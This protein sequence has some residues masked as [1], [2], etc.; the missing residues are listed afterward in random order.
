MSSSI[1]ARVSAIDW[2]AAWTELDAT[3][4]AV[5]PGLL[6]PEECRALAASYSADR[7]FRSRIVMGRHGFGRGEY[8]YFDHPLPGLVAALRTGLY[9]RLAPVADRWNEALGLDGRSPGA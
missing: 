7:G 4:S 5:L 2:A 8:K 1:P 6:Q 9:P 3:G